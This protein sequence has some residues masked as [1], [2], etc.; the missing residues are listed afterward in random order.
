MSLLFLIFIYLSQDFRAK[1][2]FAF[3]SLHPPTPALAT[4]QVKAEMQSFS[5]G[6][7]MLKMPQSHVEIFILGLCVRETHIFEGLLYLA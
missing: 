2:L 6:V 1:F 3:C 4:P 5:I 7:E